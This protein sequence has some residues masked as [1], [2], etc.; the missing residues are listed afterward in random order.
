MNDE[1]TSLIGTSEARL[2]RIKDKTRKSEILSLVQGGTLAP[3]QR[4][5]GYLTIGHAPPPELLSENIISN[6]LQISDRITFLPLLSRKSPTLF[7]DDVLDSISAYLVKFRPTKTDA[8]ATGLDRIA[9]RWFAAKNKFA[10]APSTLNRFVAIVE[11]LTKRVVSGNDRRSASS[12]RSEKTLKS[13]SRR[14][15]LSG[16]YSANLETVLQTLSILASIEEHLRPGLLSEIDDLEF[17]TAVQ[18]LM[19]SAH[20][21]LEQLAEAGDDEALERLERSLE[22]VPRN[23]QRLKAELD[24]LLS[25]RVRYPKN[26]QALLTKLAGLPETESSANFEI[27][28]DD[29]NALHITQLASTLVR[30]WSARDE[31]PKAKEAFEELTVVLADFF[32]IEIKGFVGSVESFNARVHEFPL[33]EKTASRVKLVRPWVQISGSQPSRILIKALVV[34][35]S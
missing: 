16:S 9:T 26:V 21:R 14:A 8:I 35:A 6:A 23:S 5:R 15:I 27:S 25:N 33:G 18:H 12:S 24:R 10:I 17:D 31:G 13:L 7:A 4:L 11:V 32:G 19:S 29:A 30:A 2:R 34:A 22:R 28:T 3:E 20:A 1:I